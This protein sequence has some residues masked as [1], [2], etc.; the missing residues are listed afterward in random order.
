[1]HF[2]ARPLLTFKRVS[3]K[4]DISKKYKGGPFGLAGG[5]ILREVVHPYTPP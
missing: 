3:A 4:M 5:R 2:L 1:M